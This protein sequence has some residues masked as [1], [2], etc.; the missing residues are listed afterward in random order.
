MPEGFSYIPLLTERETWG[1]CS[2]KHV[3]PPEQEPSITNDD[4]FSGKAT[5]ILLFVQ[6]LLFVQSHSTNT[7]HLSGEH[8]FRC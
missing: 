4:G 7:L 5:P 1:V 8:F 2:Y 3:A 6:T